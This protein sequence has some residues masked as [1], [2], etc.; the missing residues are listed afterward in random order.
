MVTFKK[1]A[2][3][4][5]LTFLVVLLFVIGFQSKRIKKLIVKLL[6]SQHALE[7][8]ELESKK[9]KLK[10]EVRDIDA[11]RREKTRALR[12]YLKQ[13]RDKKSSK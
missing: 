3:F 4:I 6:E 11:K 8:Q 12:A 10:K 1:I 9:Q 2:L 13:L 7:T 5:G